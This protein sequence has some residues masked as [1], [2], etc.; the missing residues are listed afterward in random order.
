MKSFIKYFLLI[1]I[2]FLY[3]STVNA[4]ELNEKLS[5][6][7]I[8][9]GTIQCQE[10][11]SQTAAENTC[12]AAAPIQPE[13]TYRATMHDRLFL[14]LGFAAGHGLYDVSPFNT[15]PWGADLE[16]DVENINGSGRDYIL[17]AWY[18]RTFDLENNSRLAVTLGIIDASSYLDQ[19]AYA[20]DEYRQFMNP[21][22]SNA[23]NAFFPA[24]D[25]GIAAEWFYENWV[26][27]AI[28]MDVYQATS[29]D[30]YSF[31]GVQAAY[32]LETTLGTG[33]YR[34]VVNGD[35]NFIDQAGQ[36][37]QQNDI[38][39]ISLDQQFGDEIAAF[40]RI[41]WRL[42][43]QPIDYTA[44]YSGGIDISGISW[45]RLPDNIG[46][47]LVYLEGDDRRMI[48]TRIAEAYYRMV[49]NTYL[50][51]TFDIQYMHDEYAQS[52]EAKG[53]IYSLRATLNY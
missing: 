36:S 34:I 53:M 44:I 49:I 52:A 19:N 21:A 24:Y 32:R 9:A 17:E 31:Y 33:N 30:K 20:N 25:P 27:T 28:Y 45:N 5:L 12:K 35:R 40:T 47:G 8:L 14:K 23:P 42:D 4:Y 3:V 1:S 10:L 13:L 6:N 29:S 51:L 41:G 11:S 43:D 37:K 38:L 22:L 15:A 18:A 46:L 50:A 16:E 26:F 39:V 2:S 48:N 7:G